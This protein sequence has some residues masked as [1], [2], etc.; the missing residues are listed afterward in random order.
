M[1]REGMATSAVVDK[2]AALFLF[3]IDTGI[4]GSDAEGDDEVCL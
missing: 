4:R 1:L 3:F 2:A